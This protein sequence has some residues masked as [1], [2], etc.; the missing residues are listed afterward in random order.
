[1]S[2]HSTD[3]PGHDVAGAPDGVRG[4]EPVG[5]GSGPFATR[6]LAGPGADVDRLRPVGP[7]PRP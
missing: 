6:L 3:P 1:M 4:D 7:G 2:R 5:T